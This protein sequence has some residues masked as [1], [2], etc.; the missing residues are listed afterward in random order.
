MTA[1]IDDDRGVATVWA[2]GAIAVLVSM[3]MFGVYLGEAAVTRHH[4]ESAADLAA[5][6]GAA[7]VIGGEQYACAQARRIT[8]RMHVRLVSCQVHD[9][10][11]LVDVAAQPPGWLGSLGAATARARAG[12]VASSSRHS[13]ERAAMAMTAACVEGSETTV[14]TPGVVRGDGY[15]EGTSS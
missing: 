3:A 2:A 10:D 8:D 4:A 6:A 7:Q 11:V 1:G 9:W 15:P 13:D 12:P 5:L 14:P